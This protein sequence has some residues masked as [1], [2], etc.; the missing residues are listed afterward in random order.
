MIEKKLIRPRINRRKARQLTVDSSQPKAKVKLG[1]VNSP[2]SHSRLEK[3]PN[4]AQIEPIAHPI[5]KVH[6]QGNSALLPPENN[7]KN[8]RLGETLQ[9]VNE[10]LAEVESSVPNAQNA[11]NNYNPCSTVTTMNYMLANNPKFRGDSQSG[12]VHDMVSPNLRQE[13]KS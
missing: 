4:S 11:K 3:E 8:K 10:D 7:Q 2:T 5:S 9:K 13:E 1:G 6:P 12:N